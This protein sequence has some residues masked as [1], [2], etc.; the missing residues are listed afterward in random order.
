MA[1]LVE[2]GP[3][4]PELLRELGALR[5]GQVAAPEQRSPPGRLDDPEQEE[6]EDDDEGERPQRAEDLPTLTC[7]A[8]NARV[9]A[10]RCRVRA[11]AA[12]RTT[13]RRGEKHERTIIR[14]R[15]LGARTA[16]RR[17]TGFRVGVCR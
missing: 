5:V 7:R 15:R 14:A 2:L 13:I 8:L 11:D 16:A 9:G 12:A 6:V 1:E 10:L 4:E 17:L 3:V